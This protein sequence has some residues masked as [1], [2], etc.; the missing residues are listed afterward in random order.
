M[1]SVDAMEEVYGGEVCMCWYELSR[2]TG[3]V[4]EFPNGTIL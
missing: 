3:R 1:M 2:G 4:I